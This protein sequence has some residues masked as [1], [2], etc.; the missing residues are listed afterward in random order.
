MDYV[1]NPVSPFGYR[2]VP[3]TASSYAYNELK[4]FKP[5]L[6]SHLFIGKRIKKKIIYHHDKLSIEPFVNARGG[7]TFFNPKYANTTLHGV[8]SIDINSSYP[9]VYTFNAMPCLRPYIYEGA[10]PYLNTCKYIYFYYIEIS[11]LSFKHSYNV[12]PPFIPRT[13]EN[14]GVKGRYFVNYSGPAFKIILPL[15]EL[16]LFLKHYEIAL[17]VIRTYRY[18]RT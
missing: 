12:F 5:A 8:N 15:E 17:N 18:A 4:K 2:S 1:D 16:Q 11:Y 6:F 9:S 14:V 7:Y 10:I 3:L 13:I